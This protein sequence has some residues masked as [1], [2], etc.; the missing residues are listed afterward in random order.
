MHNKSAHRS[1]QAVREKTGLRRAR[2]GGGEI[3]GSEKGRR[4]TEATERVEIHRQRYNELRSEEHT[5]ELQS[6]CNLVC[7]LLLEKKNISRA[8]RKLGSSS[9]L[10][11]SVLASPRIFLHIWLSGRIPRC[12]SSWYNQVPSSPPS[13]SK[14]VSTIARLDP[15]SRSMNLNLGSPVALRQRTVPLIPSFLSAASS[16]LPSTMIGTPASDCSCRSSKIRIA[17][18]IFRV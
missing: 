11:T 18:S 1:A 10:L 5:S 2:L 7:R 16:L 14:S 3:G 17:L 13:L 15:S 8:L 12:D 9:T 4:K 6:P